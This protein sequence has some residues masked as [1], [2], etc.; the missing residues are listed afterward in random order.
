MAAILRSGKFLRIVSGL[1]RQRTEISSD[2]RGKSGPQSITNSPLIT[3]SYSGSVQQFHSLSLQQLYNA[4]PVLNPEQ[5]LDKKKNEDS[6]L[7]ILERRGSDPL[8]EF[9]VDKQKLEEAA[10]NLNVVDQDKGQIGLNLVK[11]LKEEESVEYV[12]PVKLAVQKPDT[13]ATSEKSQPTE[14]LVKEQPLQISLPT[15]TVTE[16][17]NECINEN[18]EKVVKLNH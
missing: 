6:T 13:N 7:H 11:E 10:K 14:P 18:A 17:P 1:T 3:S 9:Y 2:E 8:L 12:E 4:L 15:I 16:P 5:E